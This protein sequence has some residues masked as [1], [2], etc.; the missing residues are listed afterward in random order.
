MH[1][2]CVFVN[3]SRYYLD[4]LHLVAILDPNLHNC[5]LVAHVNRVLSQVSVVQAEISVCE[6]T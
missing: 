2:V 4:T 5:R 6:E 3:T 1:I